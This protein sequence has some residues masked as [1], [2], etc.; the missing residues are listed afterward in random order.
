[1]GPGEQTV[2][3][4]HGDLEHKEEADLRVN[5]GNKLTLILNMLPLQ[6]TLGNLKIK[7]E[8]VLMLK[9]PMMNGE[10]M[11]QKLHGDLLQE[12]KKK[13]NSRVN[14]GNKHIA[15]LSIPLPWI[16]QMPLRQQELLLLKVK[17]FLT[18]GERM[19]LKP[20]GDLELNSQV[21]HLMK[22]G[23]T[24]DIPQSWIEL[25]LPKHLELLLSL[26]LRLKTSGE[27][28]VQQPHGDLEPN[29]RRTHGIKKILK[30]DTELLWKELMPMRLRELQMLMVKLNPMSGEEKALRK[31]GVS[32]IQRDGVTLN[33][34]LF[35]EHLLLHQLLLQ[36]LPQL[37]QPLQLN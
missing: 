30:L 7:E 32:K 13:A 15:L 10:T 12:H 21:N 19:D 33:L 31:H 1:M 23:P 3:R 20:H 6:T 22:F 14:H 11:V 36:L 24:M 35:K 5:H 18:L 4:P 17:N 27:R 16:E 9:L 34:R 37:P 26:K 29:L 8:Q 2:Q 28:M 25:M